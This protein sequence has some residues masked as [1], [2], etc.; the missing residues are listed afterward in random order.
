MARRLDSVNLWASMGTTHSNLH[1][2]SRHGLLVVLRG[3]KTVEVFPPGEAQRI[4][5]YPVSDPLRAH[6]AAAP[7]CCLARRLNRAS[8]CAGT[9]SG[10]RCLN[11][12][13]DARSFQT[14][15]RLGDALLIPEGWW[16]HVLTTGVED[17]SAG[18]QSVGL[19]V[20]IWWRGYPRE[21]AA[22]RP[23]VLRRLL[24][25]MLAKRTAFHVSVRSRRSKKFKSKGT[26]KEPADSRVRAKGDCLAMLAAA[27]RT[28][29]APHHRAWRLALRACGDDLPHELGAAAGSTE[30]DASSL[31]A[32]LDSLDAAQAA[33]LLSSLDAAAAEE[34]SGGAAAASLRKLWQAYPQ[35]A[36]VAKWADHLQH[37]LSVRFQI[38]C[39]A[40]G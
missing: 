8:A 26:K 17:A 16:H 35:R 11:G 9:R 18:G 4:G 32:L 30:T 10:V 21:P 24:G 22:A 34:R 5:A 6:H 31:H 36:I 25:D 12:M 29:Q 14:T 33:A 1:Y 28:S 40:Q 27:A 3:Q 13:R 37:V 7:H 23:Y 15:L 19:A 2:D 20:N 39:V 38:C